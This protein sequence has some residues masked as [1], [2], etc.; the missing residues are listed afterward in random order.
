MT[1]WHKQKDTEFAVGVGSSKPFFFTVYREVAEKIYG[2]L[3]S[4]GYTRAYIDEAPS[5]PL[6]ERRREFSTS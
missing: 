2:I 3:Y 4:H 1:T 6:A 5:I